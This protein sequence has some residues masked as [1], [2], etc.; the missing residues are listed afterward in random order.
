MHRASLSHKG[1]DMDDLMHYD[2][3]FLYSIE[4]LLVDYVLNLEKSQESILTMLM[5]YGIQRVN[6]TMKCILEKK[7]QLFVERVSVPSSLIKLSTRGLFY[8]KVISL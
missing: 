8:L 3:G 7:H 5:D 6:K 2:M 1:M 4:G